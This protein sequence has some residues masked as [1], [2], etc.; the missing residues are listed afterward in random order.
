MTSSKKIV[1]SAS[2]RTDIPAFY[3][4]DFMEDIRR[5]FFCI[6]NPFNQ[7]KSLIMATPDKVHT[8]VFW[9]KDYTNFIK[10]N[11]S[12]SFRS[13]DITCFLII[14]L[15]PRIPSLNLAFQ[16]LITG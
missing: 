6:T 11:L 13:W 14:Q 15:I 7:K 1:I 5:G 12:K 10:G 2:R 3:M 4:N 16:L 8:I 9:S